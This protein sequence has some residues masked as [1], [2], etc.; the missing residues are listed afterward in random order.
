MMTREATTEE[1]ERMSVEE[2]NAWVE[3]QIW[4]PL[5]ELEAADF[6]N[7][8][9]PKVAISLRLPE[10]LLA[11]VKALAAERGERYQRVLRHLIELGLTVQE[12]RP[13]VDPVEVRL[14]REQVRELARRGELT[15]HLRAS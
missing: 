12:S 6:R 9:V 13:R 7:L 14:S 11:D 4:S 8:R 3:S 15:V 1:L 2:L 5:S 10:Q